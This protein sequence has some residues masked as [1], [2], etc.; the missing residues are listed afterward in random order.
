M[1]PFLARK[2]KNVIVPT[3]GRVAEMG[4][5]QTALFQTA[6]MVREPRSHDPSQTA[7]I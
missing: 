7:S 4:E 6:N 5:E 1:I 3:L 2:T